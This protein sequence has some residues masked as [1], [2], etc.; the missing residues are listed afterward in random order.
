MIFYQYEWV[1]AFVLAFA[2]FT[3]G[4]YEAR[5]GDSKDHAWL[6]AGLSIFLSALCIRFISTQWQLVLF[7]QIVLY[8]AI[9]VFRV[10][11]ESA[12]S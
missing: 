10:L 1:L 6:W 9:A 12:R 5:D 8:I 4:K 7:I 11:L 3:M 2:F